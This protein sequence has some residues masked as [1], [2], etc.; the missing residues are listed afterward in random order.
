M[1]LSLKALRKETFCSA[2]GAVRSPRHNVA[3]VP[4]SSTQRVLGCGW[5][6]GRRVVGVHALGLEE[7]SIN[8]HGLL[9]SGVV[10]SG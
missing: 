9:Q 3:Y 8:M 4:V 5:N 1:S 7:P 10:K 2:R 6:P